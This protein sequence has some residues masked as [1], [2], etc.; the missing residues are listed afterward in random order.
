MALV[1]LPLIAHLLAMHFFGHEW[2]VLIRVSYHYKLYS[3]YNQNL[4]HAHFE[5]YLSSSLSLIRVSVKLVNKCR[6]Y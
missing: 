5:N 2:S 6:P 4:V 3:V 1:V